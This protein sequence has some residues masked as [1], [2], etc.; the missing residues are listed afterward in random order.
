MGSGSG[1]LSEQG[2]EHETII[3]WLSMSV[4][5]DILWRLVG[6]NL[7]QISDLGIKGELLLNGLF[8]AN[9][10]PTLTCDFLMD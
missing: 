2:R 3:D 9:V 4:I 10:W 6:S 7:G 1:I 8:V 5:V